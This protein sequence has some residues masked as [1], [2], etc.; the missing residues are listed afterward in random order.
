MYANLNISP[1]FILTPDISLRQKISHALS[2]ANAATTL[3]S[4]KQTSL[5]QQHDQSDSQ[6]FFKVVAL[7]IH[8][9]KLQCLEVHIMERAHV[10]YSHTRHKLWIMAL[11]HAACSTRAAEVVMDHV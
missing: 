10:D 9:L 7:S 5:E 1:F 4:P 2:D 6:L 3:N 11:Q 8:W